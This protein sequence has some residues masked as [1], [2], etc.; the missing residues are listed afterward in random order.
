MYM[1]IHIYKIINTCTCIISIKQ[2]CLSIPDFLLIKIINKE[3]YVHV[4]K[5]N[6]KSY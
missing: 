5:C 3:T 4:N 1:S 2:S 6:S